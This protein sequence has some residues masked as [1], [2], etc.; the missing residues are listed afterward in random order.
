M[1]VLR[2]IDAALR[3]L[4]EQCGAKRIGAVGFCWGGVATHYLALKYPEI[5]AA[6]SVY[7][8][9]VSFCKSDV[10]M[11]SSHDDS[12]RRA[13]IVRERDDRYELQSPTLFIFGEKDEVIPLD[14][15]RGPST[16]IAL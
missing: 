3:F 10:I 8:V 7:G 14:Q 12:V 2:E 1:S 4:K 11:L 13:G 5:K 15:V 9:S 6:V 16:F